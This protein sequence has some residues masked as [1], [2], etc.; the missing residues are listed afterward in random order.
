MCGRHYSVFFN[1]VLFFCELFTDVCR[2]E[3]GVEEKTVI[4]VLME[5]KF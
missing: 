1:A 5:S 3:Y 2:I 4:K